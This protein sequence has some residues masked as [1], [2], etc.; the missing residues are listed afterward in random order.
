VPV[1]L[2]RYIVEI[3]TDRDGTFDNALDDVTEYVTA[4]SWSNGI[5]RPYDELASVNRMRMVLFNRDRQFDV[6]RSG[7]TYAEKLYPSTLV[8]VRME[9]N[10]TG[11]GS[12]VLPDVT[13]DLMLWVGRIREVV[14]MIGRAD[15]RPLVE[16]TCED[17][18]SDLARYEFIPPLNLSILTG[19]SLDAIFAADVVRYPYDGQTAQT[20]TNFDT[21]VSTSAYAGAVDPKSVKVTALSAINDVML[22]ETGDTRFYFDARSARFTFHDR[23]R[24]L[25][26]DET[27]AATFDTSDDHIERV[28]PRFA[29]DLTTRVVYQ[30]QPRE[31]G[32]AGSVLYTMSRV[33]FDIAA[34]QSTSFAVRFQDAANPDAR[35]GASTVIT[36]VKGTDILPNSADLDVTFS[37]GAYGAEVTLENTGASTLTITKFEVRG[38]PLLEYQSEQIIV[39]D[40][41][42]IAS[43]GR[44]SRSIRSRVQDATTAGVHANYLLTTFKKP[45]RRVAELTYVVH[46]TTSAERARDLEPGDLIRVDDSAFSGHD[47]KYVIVGERHRLAPGTAKSHTVTY[48]L[49]PWI[50]NN[51]FRWGSSAWGGSQGFAS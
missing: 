30:W 42:A 27:P 25:S 7:A 6:D 50:G 23:Q 14:P 41:T 8:R 43:Y 48:I 26:L 24:D 47:S 36:P 31:T 18:T 33:P 35:T 10:G 17:L 9:V 13:R 12:V 21:G 5:M 49:H 4:L 11:A 3:D 28:R 45:R 32:S 2:V 22:Q 19:A 34:G 16:V 46:D 29:D 38:T 37:A 44:H 40:A 51:F 39:E 15:E 1:P 20:V